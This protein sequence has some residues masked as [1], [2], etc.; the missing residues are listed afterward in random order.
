[1]TTPAEP[2]GLSAAPQLGRSLHLDRAHDLVEIEGL[3]VSGALASQAR[4]FLLF[5]RETGPGE[6]APAPVTPRLRIGPEE[7]RLVA[8][9]GFEERG[10]P[11]VAWFQLLEAPAAGAEVVLAAE[12][13]EL[14]RVSLGAATKPPL[15]EAG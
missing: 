15:G 13:R 7:A 10:A 12:D 4:H 2:S 11:A 1:M 3:A 5:R 9:A 8:T 14:A 6:S